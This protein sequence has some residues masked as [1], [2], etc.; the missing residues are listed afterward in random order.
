MSLVIRD[1]TLQEVVEL[2]EG[3]PVENKWIVS[4]AIAGCMLGGHAS[5]ELTDQ[6]RSEFGLGGAL[7]G[8]Y[9]L[10]PVITIGSATIGGCVGSIAERKLKG[11]FGAF[12][13]LRG[14]LLKP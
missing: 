2:F 7:F 4:G 8:L 1:L 5:M 13:F 9:V 10:T 11:A 6:L 14:L 12:Q 3:L